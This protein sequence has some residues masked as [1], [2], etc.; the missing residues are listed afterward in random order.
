MQ[1]ISHNNSTQLFPFIG[2]SCTP[3]NNNGWK[4][5]YFH[6]ALWKHVNLMKKNSLPLPFISHGFGNLLPFTSHSLC[7][8]S[9]NV[10][11]KSYKFSWTRFWIYSLW[12]WAKNLSR[13]FYG[14]CIVGT[15]PCYILYSFN[16][17]LPHGL[18]KEDIDFER[19][20]GIAQHK[21]NHL[22]LFA[23]VPT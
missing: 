14:S 10:L 17:K 3:K 2:S 21:K 6:H 11:R 13:Y 18:V 9:H 15:C 7:N 19:M 16:W 1:P 20:P 23:K 8:C 12:I 22:C 5:H 4:I